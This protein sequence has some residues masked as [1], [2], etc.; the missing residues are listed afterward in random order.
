MPVKENQVSRTAVI[1][2]YIR[3][4]H[5][6]QD[7]PKIFNDS[8]AYYL[9]TEEERAFIEQHAARF[10]QLYDPARAASCPDQETALAWSMRAM[11][12][13]PFILSR[14]RYTEDN[15][16]QAVRQ[17]VRQ[18]VILGAGMDTF[19]FRRP[20]MLEQL[21]VFEVDHPATQVSKR[22]RIKKLG[23]RQPTQLHFVPVDFT[24][25]NLRAALTR[26]PYD[27]QTKS[28]FSWLGVTYYLS[29]QA[30]F[31]TLRT[32][33]D[34]SPADSM[35]IFDYLDTDAFVPEKAA[36]NMQIWLDNV[37]RA[38]EPLKSGYD[39]STFTA[40]LAPLGLRLH[41]NLSPADI[42]ER[43]FQGRTDGYHAREH[44]HFTCAVVE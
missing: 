2:A 13:P 44:V 15:L 5:A 36:K 1:T 20:E 8:L 38:G 4:Y 41:E 9:L 3:A 7:S 31:A 26:S 25:E 29:R 19:A 24:Q 18:Y 17:G 40:E 34:V 22:R 23:W 10:L 21:Q 43:Y 14:A 39:P 30:V 16:E 11:A 35:V 12:G 27:P 42:E 37:R 28:F 6:M 33:A 32:I